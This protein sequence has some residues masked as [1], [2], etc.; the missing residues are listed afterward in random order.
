M[1]SEDILA[2]VD[3]LELELY[4]INPEMCANGMGYKYIT[5]GCCDV[6]TFC[7]HCIYCSETDSEDDIKDA[8]GFMSFLIQER[9]RFIDML[10]KVK[11]TTICCG[12]NSEKPLNIYVKS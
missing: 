1:Y 3:C 11:N 5:N 8:G 6:V 9:D 12:G 7:E 10:I 4:D 2:V